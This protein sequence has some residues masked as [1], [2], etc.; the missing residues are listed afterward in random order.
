[1]VDDQVPMDLL[2]TI[3]LLDVAPIQEFSSACT[4]YTQHNNKVAR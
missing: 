4:P 2:A 3:K 1:M